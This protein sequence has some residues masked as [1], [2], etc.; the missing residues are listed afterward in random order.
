MG[1]Y[2]LIFGAYDRAI[3]SMMIR[4]FMGVNEVAWYGLAY[5]IYAS[6]QQ[7]AYYLVSGIFPI[8]SGNNKNKKGLFWGSAGVLIVGAMTVLVGVWI[9]APIMISILAGNGFEAAV[10]VLRILSIALVFS[11]LGHLVGFTLISR[12]G[13]RELLGLG[14]I[15]LL[16]NFGANLV[17]IPRF[18]IEGAAWVTAAT[19]AISLVLMSLRLRK[20]A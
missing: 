8:L 2:L 14:I 15:V 16:F 9:F 12:D 19:E 3:D 13:Q 7:P 1:M 18:G 20:R 10:P 17:V 6:L 5:K 4:R 11:Y